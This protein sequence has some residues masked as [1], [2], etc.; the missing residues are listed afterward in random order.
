MQ[1]TKERIRK[2]QKIT[3]MAY[4]ILQATAWTPRGLFE[5]LLFEGLQGLRVSVLTGPY[6]RMIPWDSLSSINSLCSI[7]CPM[8][9]RK[10]KTLN[11]YRLLPPPTPCLQSIYTVLVS[12]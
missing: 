4:L 9:L 11:I 1:K 6:L 2:R 10:E 8:K 5:P 12:A 3:T 7:L